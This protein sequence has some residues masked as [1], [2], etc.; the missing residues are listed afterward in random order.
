MADWYWMKNG[1][2]HGPVDTAH[3][4]QL[5]RTGQIGPTDTIWREGLPNWVPASQANGLEFGASRSAHGG[6]SV[7]KKEVEPFHEDVPEDSAPKEPPEI[8]EPGT[9]E[10][11]S[12]TLAQFRELL[13]DTS[14]NIVPQLEAASAEIRRALEQ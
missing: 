7:G 3:L 6:T 8:A 11:A 2:E 14:R 10:P 13:E 5:A 4:K 12:M 9:P 1:E